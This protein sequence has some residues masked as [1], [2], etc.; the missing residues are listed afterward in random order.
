MSSFVGGLAASAA[1]AFVFA[2]VD[3]ALVAG[4]VGAAAVVA[5]VA[6]AGVAA[7]GGTGGGG[8]GGASCDWA[9][10]RARIQ[11]HMMDREKPD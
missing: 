11:Q 3:G 10:T 8:V 1:D 9:R 4:G 5:G 7:V 2:G 6:V